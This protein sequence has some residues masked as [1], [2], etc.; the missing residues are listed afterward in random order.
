MKKKKIT[1]YVRTE[2][3]LRWLCD[4]AEAMERISFVYVRPDKGES[5]WYVEWK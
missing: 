2:T 4:Y 5:M 3:L 1:N